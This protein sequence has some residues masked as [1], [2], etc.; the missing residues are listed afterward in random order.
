MKKKL[1]TAIKFFTDG[2]VF[3]FLTNTVGYV[4]FA[5]SGVMYAS[6]LLEH[7]NPNLTTVGVT[8]F[9]ISAVLSNISYRAAPL[10]D[11]EDKKLLMYSGKNSFI[12]LSLLY[13]QLFSAMLLMP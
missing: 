6:Q 7:D 1:K 12:H 5:L 9:S 8:A 11:E 10:F 2:D 13:R 3:V 4:L